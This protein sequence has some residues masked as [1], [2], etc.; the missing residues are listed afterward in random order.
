[1]R[2]RRPVIAILNGNEVDKFSSVTS[3]ANILGL[4]PGNVYESATKGKTIKG[5]QFRFCDKSE[6]PPKP[7][8]TATSLI[9]DIEGHRFYSDECPNKVNCRECDIFRLWPSGYQPRCFEYSC[10]GKLIV[11]H[12]QGREMV[13]KEQ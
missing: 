8:R 9:A 5:Y 2:P 6:L 10:N 13:W 12:C 11:Q 7:K 3:A 4:N 1:M